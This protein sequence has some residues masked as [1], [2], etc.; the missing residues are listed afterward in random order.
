M[1]NNEKDN[2]GIPPFIFT[3][4]ILVEAEPLGILQA[5]NQGLLSR[6]AAWQTLRLIHD[7]EI[8][9]NLPQ[10]GIITVFSL[11]KDIE[12]F[13]KMY[14][15]GCDMLRNEGIINEETEKALYEE[16]NNMLKKKAKVSV[17]NPLDKTSAS[18]KKK[19][20]KTSPTNKTKN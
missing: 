16:L 8:K 20:K 15:Q 17:K 18:G 1:T 14:D 10:Y 9:C 5:I 13:K 12:E 4:N 19:K 7:K 11:S 2:D 3:S 6:F